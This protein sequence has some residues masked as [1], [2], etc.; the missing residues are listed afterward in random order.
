M[1]HDLKPT[2]SFEESFGI[3]DIR[4]GRV[5][6]VELLAGPKPA[7]KLL[8][9]E[10]GALHSAQARRDDWAACDGRAQFR[11]SGSE[12]GGFGVPDSGRTVSPRRQRRSDSDYATEQ[13]SKN[14]IQAVLALGGIYYS[15]MH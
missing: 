1:A 10:R 9:D 6:S 4:L 12:R 8:V 7:Y 11:T 13:R 15:A 2:V 3:L 5:L 14:W